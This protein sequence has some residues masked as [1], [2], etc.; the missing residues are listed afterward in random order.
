MNSKQ[1]LGH[2]KQEIAR[3]EKIRDLLEAGEAEDTPRP[4]KSPSK[5]PTKAA[6][7]G[8]SKIA[9]YW[10]A[11]TPEQRTAEMQRRMKVSKAKK[12]AKAKAKS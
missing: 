12:K 4:A 2:V 1:F 5:K 7:K 3:L 8:P 11:M 10:A 6:K 9:A